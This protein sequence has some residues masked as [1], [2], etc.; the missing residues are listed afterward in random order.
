MFDFCLFPFYIL[1]HFFYFKTILVLFCYFILFIMSVH[2]L[3]AYCRGGSTPASPFGGMFSP[4]SKARMGIISPPSILRKRK[5]NGVQNAGSPPNAQEIFQTP[6]LS[7]ASIF[8]SFLFLF[9]PSHPSNQ[10][11]RRMFDMN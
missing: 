5:R 1:I 2:P 6:K 3:T 8:V 11:L 10:M 7:D 9:L 4:K